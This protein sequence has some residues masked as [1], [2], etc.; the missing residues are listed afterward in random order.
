[1]LLQDVDLAH[2]SVIELGKEVATCESSLV[3]SEVSINRLEDSWKTRLSIEGAK[4]LSYD[5]VGHHKRSL[6]R[7]HLMGVRILLQELGLIRCVT[8]RGQEGVGEILK[9]HCVGGLIL[10]VKAF[11]FFLVAFE[12]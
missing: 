5:V 8:L 10:F 7:W 11:E 3:F 1:V 2:L 4:W 9:H 12:H 6:S